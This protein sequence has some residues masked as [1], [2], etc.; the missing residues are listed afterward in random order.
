MSD[1]IMKTLTPS[2]HNR[3]LPF[4]T[5]FRINNF[6]YNPLLHKKVT[7]LETI[8]SVATSKSL[9]ANLR[10]ITTYWAT[11][12][13]D[14]DLLHT[15]FDTNYSQIIACGAGVDNPVDILFTAYAVIPWALFRLYIKNKADQHT[16]GMAT[17]THEELILL[18]TNKYNLL[19]QTG[20]WG[21][22][23]LEEEKSLQCKQGSL[24]SKVNLPWAPNLGPQ[25]AR[26][27]VTRR[28]SVTRGIKQA[29]QDE[30]EEEEEGHCKQT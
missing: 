22:K 11:V 26:K 21:A 20:E 9:H 2:A 8:N 27:M 18:A 13:G 28:T 23:T 19:M 5:G 24:L 29:R 30:E 15:Y 16:G 12:K 10:E 14:T 25:L 3:L 7:A 1:C 6:V 17:F 4:T